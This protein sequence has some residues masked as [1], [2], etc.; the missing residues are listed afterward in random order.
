MSVR[1]VRARRG[2][3]IVVHRN[4]GSFDDGGCFTVIALGVVTAQFLCD[5]AKKQLQFLRMQKM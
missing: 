4:H 1:H 3:H 5:F 2:E